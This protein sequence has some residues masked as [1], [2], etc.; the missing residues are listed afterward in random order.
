MPNRYYIAI[1]CF[2]FFKAIY[3]HNVSDSSLRI[4]EFNLK[5][6]IDENYEFNFKVKN[7]FLDKLLLPSK[8]QSVKRA[9][10]INS[11]GKEITLATVTADK[12]GWKGSFDGMLPGWNWFWAEGH[13]SEDVFM[14]YK[15]KGP[16]SNASA[17]DKKEIKICENEDVKVELLK[18]E[19]KAGEVTYRFKYES[20]KSED[21]IAP[22]LFSIVSNNFGSEIFHSEVIFD[23]DKKAMEVKV[24]HG[25]SASGVY[26]VWIVFPEQ[27]RNTICNF[28]VNL[29][30]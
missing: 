11:Y 7:M 6:I 22:G 10:I 12:N 9:F 4:S 19:F 3:A 8:R 29:K 20:R 17:D 18:N 1:F 2:L 16:V 28:K 27:N 26:R 15:F 30:I 21:V 5:K 24:P 23:K 25:I 14:F 13:F